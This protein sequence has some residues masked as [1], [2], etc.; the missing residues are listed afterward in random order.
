M[1]YSMLFAGELRA[2]ADRLDAFLDSRVDVSSHDDWIGALDTV[3]HHQGTVRDLFARLPSILI[4]EAGS[5]LEVRLGAAD[6]W[7]GGVLGEDDF[8]EH[9]TDLAAAFRNAASFGAEGALYFLEEQVA[10][11]PQEPELTYRVRVG[12]GLSDVAHVPEKEQADVI[13][14][15][16][17]LRVGERVAEILGEMPSGFVGKKKPRRGGKRKQ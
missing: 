12:R 8:G 13:A 6:V 9:A 17:F 10:F 2:S 14:G 1:S 5:W 4:T 11:C 7:L 3:G 15:P 16:I